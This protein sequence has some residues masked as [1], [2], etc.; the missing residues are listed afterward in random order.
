MY[1]WHLSLESSSRCSPPHDSTATRR[2]GP[3]NRRR[4]AYECR[5]MELHHSQRPMTCIRFPARNGIGTGVKDDVEPPARLRSDTTTESNDLRGILRRDWVSS[6]PYAQLHVAPAGPLRS[7]LLAK[8]LELLLQ[9]VQPPIDDRAIHRSDCVAATNH[10]RTQ[11]NR[12][13]DKKMACCRAH[14][15]RPT[16]ES[17]GRC[18]V[19]RD[20]TQTR[21][22]GSLE[23]IARR[24]LVP[25]AC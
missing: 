9:L 17:S 22:S 6:F 3:L 16:L 11:G 2:G 24:H 15:S 7:T 4:N 25:A 20:N 12:V 5:W 13:F 8:A 19:P 18:R 10:Q 23:R 14:Q 21:R 1:A